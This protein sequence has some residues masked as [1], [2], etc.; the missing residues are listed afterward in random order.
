VRFSFMAKKVGNDSMT[1]NVRKAF[2]AEIERQLGQ[3]I[4][5]WEHKRMVERPMLCDGDGPI[6]IFRRWAKQFYIDPPKDV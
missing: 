3:D 1:E 4:P 2:I 6:G 5:I